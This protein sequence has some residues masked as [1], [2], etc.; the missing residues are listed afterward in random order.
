[1]L[2]NTSKIP[3]LRLACKQV[4]E[5]GKKGK[6]RK[7][8]AYCFHNITY[9]AYIMNDEQHQ[10]SLKSLVGLS[11]GITINYSFYS[12]L[13]HPYHLTYFK[14]TLAMRSRAFPALSIGPLFSAE[15]E[16]KS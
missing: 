3:L 4:Q 10:K 14:W 12:S 2:S 5:S 8:M 11:T 1:M 13:H 6:V 9:I 16:F 15:S 7:A